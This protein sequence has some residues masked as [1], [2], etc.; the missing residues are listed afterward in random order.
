[1]NELLGFLQKTDRDVNALT[2]RGLKGSVRKGLANVIKIFT[3]TV[4]VPALLTDVR[5]F[6]N[7]MT[8]I[9]K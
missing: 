9:F 3:C 6:G 5:D 1:M 4:C 2:P 8:L 7:F